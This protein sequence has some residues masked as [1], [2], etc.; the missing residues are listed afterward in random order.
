MMSSLSWHDKS[1]SQRCDWLDLIR[2][3]AAIVM[4]EA[5]CVNAW[6]QHNLI[7]N[8]L[9]FLNG[10]VAPGFIMCAGY[11]QALSVFKS[12]GSLRP[13]LPTAKRIGIILLCA[14]MLHAPKLTFANWPNIVT[15][16]DCREF[17]KIDTLQCIAVSIL[18][19]HVIA[20]AI[21]Q[22]ITYAAVVTALAVGVAVVAPNLWQPSVANGLW[23]PIRGFI[24][25]NSDRGVTALFP[26]VP[27]FAF[28][29]FG[30]ALGICYRQLRVLTTSGQAKWSE[31][32]WLFI[33]TITSTILCL[34]SSCHTETWLIGKNWPQ[35]E[36]W[37]L[38]NMTLPSVTQRL[39]IV[40][41]IGSVLCWLESIRIKL[42]G[43]N[44]IKTAGNESLLIYVLH[45]VIIFRFLL[46]DPIRSYTGW[47]WYALDWNTT[48][49]ITTAIIFISITASIQWNK[50]PSNLPQIRKLQRAVFVTVSIWIIGIGVG[51]SNVP[52]ATTY[53]KVEGQQSQTHVHPTQDRQASRLTSNTD[54]KMYTKLRSAS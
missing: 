44:I 41:I 16:Q 39:S 14:Y 46:V 31:A 2:G 12:D 42:P 20:R 27:W 25:G 50:L 3:L 26:I 52:S 8:W 19:L 32:K 35:S 38:H 33:I 34:W 1:P 4:I 7:P 45:V 37:R 43:P 28:A 17:F 23:L 11:S 6:L 54:I 13:F 40:C 47:H 10:L 51:I 30:S 48:I 29:A 22:P 36:Q 18:I 5:H 24:N 49:A 9:D 21:R 53:A 15:L